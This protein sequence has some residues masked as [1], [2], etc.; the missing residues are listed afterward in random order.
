[1]LLDRLAR[2]GLGSRRWQLEAG[3][4]LVCLDVACAGVADHLGRKLWR[5]GLLVPA[6]GRE[7][8]AEVLLVEGRLLAARLVPLDGPEPRGV[9]REHLVDQRDLAIDDAELE[10]GV[11]DDDPAFARHLRAVAVEGKRA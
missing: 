3:Q 4:S 5:R 7:P 1:M 2:K 8:V 11:G 6:A 10:L 9:G